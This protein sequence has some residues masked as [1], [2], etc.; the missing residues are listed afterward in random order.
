MEKN[1]KNVSQYSIFML[2]V[3]IHDSILILFIKSIITLK[4][5]VS[6]RK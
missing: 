6:F 2:Y 4:E 5:E 3:K 1:Y